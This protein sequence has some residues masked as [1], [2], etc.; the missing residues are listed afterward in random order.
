MLK[1]RLEYM[2]GLMC[3]ILALQIFDL[4]EEGKWVLSGT[5]KSS[6]GAV[7]KVTWAHPEFGQIIATCAF[8]RSAA[9]YEEIGNK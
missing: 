5:M 4:N 3:L 8:D 2:K 9:I 7:W 6:N 1:Y